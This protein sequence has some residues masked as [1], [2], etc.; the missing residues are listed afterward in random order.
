[1][2]KDVLGTLGKTW[3]VLR[4]LLLQDVAGITTVTYTFRKD[5]ALKLTSSVPL[6]QGTAWLKFVDFLLSKFT[7]NSIV[8]RTIFR[9]YKKMN[10]LGWLRMFGSCFSVA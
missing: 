2:W 9:V 3:I 7:H 5:Y 6:R 8:P 10:Q 1:M 4:A